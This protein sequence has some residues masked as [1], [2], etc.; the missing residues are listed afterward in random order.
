[1]Y[2]FV[3][4]VWSAEDPAAR[5]QAAQLE[6]RLRRTSVPWENLLRT[7]GVSVFALPPTDPTLRSYV[8]PGEAGVVLGRLF[9]ADLSKPHLDPVEQI[10]E[11]ATREILRS[12]G[13]HLARNF[14]GGYVAL[15]ADRETRCGYA[16]RDCSGKIPC[17]YRSFR[18]V[19]IAF[20]DIGDLA[21]LE[22]PAPTVNWEYLAAF[23]YSSQAQVRACAFNE[24]QEVLA[25]ECLRVQ[26]R[27]ASQT[28]LWDPRTIV[29]Q[30]RVDRYEA[31]VDEL[32]EVAQKC[33]DAW[34]HSH[35]PMLLGLSGGFDSA[36]VLGCLGRSPA[37]PKITGLHQY[38][39]VSH[40]DEREYARA[41][42]VRAGVTLLELPMDSAADRFDSR[43]FST[44]QTS[45]PSVTALF[46]LLEIEL[47][48]R[49]AEETGARTL[50]TGQG[51]DH[52]FLQITEPL[53]AAD[54]LDIRG[55][56]PGFVAAVRDAALLSRQPYWFVLK[57]ACSRRRS[58]RPAP[59]SLAQAA[60]FVDPAALPDDVDDYVSHP[61][62]ADV[63]DLPRGK[64]MQIRFLSQVVNRH[65]PIARLERAPQHHPLLSQPLM[66]VCLQIPTYLLLRGGRERA[67][68]R[69]A[70]ADRVPAQILRRRD[71]GSIVSHATEMLRQGEPFVRELLL[72]GALAG[73]GVIVRKELEPYI[74]QGQ[75][76]REEHLLPLLACIAAEVWART[77]SHSAAAV[78]A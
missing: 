73:A 48:N 72:D 22:L 45:K 37:R 35:D 71:K 34:A 25:G 20:A 29:R 66:E 11:G 43:L 42:A 4:L 54:Y 28:V 69:Q 77:S 74:V 65:R 3:A 41:A 58:T 50:W 46:R 60:C 31:A 68:A 75:P 49:I 52:I 57:A 67:L 47:V 44:P 16:L 13:G 56:R 40:E 23:I 70:F 55:L 15:L 78:A 7:A 2:H 14:W 27:S 8:L 76:F 12:G 36:V 5:E 9:S 39:A 62:G 21:P 32:R 24:I 33:I 1:M 64:Q 51:G 30:R 53:S 63:G 19:T 17:Y 26:G 61:W 38:T 59:N 18:D 10:D 6:H